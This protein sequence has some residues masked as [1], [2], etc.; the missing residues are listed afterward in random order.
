MT[1]VDFF[2]TMVQPNTLDVMLV[3]VAYMII[4]TINS[5]LKYPPAFV[6]L[7]NPFRALLD[8]C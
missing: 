3:C 5:N 8:L 4:N 2:F 1:D 6:V 7:L